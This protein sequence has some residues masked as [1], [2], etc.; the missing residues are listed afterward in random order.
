MS[1][2]IQRLSEFHIGGDT[3]GLYILLPE[4]HEFTLNNDS[5]LIKYLIQALK[6]TVL[7]G[8]PPPLKI[9]NETFGYRAPFT[10]Q[11]ITKDFK[12][13]VYWRAE[14]YWGELE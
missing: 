3:F 4:T 1:R 7:D 12:T 2:P 14:L 13:C 11:E 8:F 9:E 5:S 10:D 6:T